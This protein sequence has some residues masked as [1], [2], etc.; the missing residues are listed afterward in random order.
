MSYQAKYLKYKQKYNQLKEQLGSGPNPY[1]LEGKKTILLSCPEFN[2]VVDKIMIKDNCKIIKLTKDNTLESSNIIES[3]DELESKDNDISNLELESFEKFAVK[4]RFNKDSDN[5]KKLYVRKTNKLV[6]NNFFRGY[7]NWNKYDDGTPD[8]KMDDT[9]TA[10]IRDSKIVFLA[11]FTFNEPNVTSII[12]QIMF[13]NSLVHYGVKEITIILPYFPV[14]TMERIV[15]EGELPS[16]D[17]LAQMLNA[18]PHASGKNNIIILDIHALASRHFFH[19]N[20][21]PIMV[22]VLPEY[23]DWI[24]KNYPPTET[25]NNIIVFPDD[26]AKKR[27]EKLL[28]SDTKTVL[29][30]KIR[31]KDK[32]IIKLEEG[33]QHIK[34]EPGITN[35]LFI[36]DDLVQSGGTTKETVNG[37]H[38]H[39]MEVES[40]HLNTYNY[41][42]MITHSVL[43]SD[44][45]VESLFKIEDKTDFNK[46]TISKLITTNS[47]PLRVVELKNKP[48]YAN[49]IEIIEIS[50]ILYDVLVNPL[51]TKYI[52]PYIL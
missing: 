47:R 37:I 48:E 10:N 23:L 24:N 6:S 3:Y 45:K 44:S 34:N 1:I 51:G 20:L 49:K 19:T 9:T 8:I 16:G 46:G 28:S 5:T 39:L 35:N 12:S 21:R 2:S 7:I 33:T 36:I 43:P 52:A 38:T 26:G 11:Y 40:N 50:N 15:G 32:R 22:S 18:I 30:T 31:E 42:T 27:Y 14:G 29:C 25:N 41:L 17:S 13:L 4:S